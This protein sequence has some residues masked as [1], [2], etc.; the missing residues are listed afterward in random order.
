MR[1]PCTTHHDSKANYRD[2][3][4]TFKSPQPCPSGACLSWI[5]RNVVSLWANQGISRRQDGNCWSCS[6]RSPAMG[7][8][9]RFPIVHRTS[10]PSISPL[11]SARSAFG[12][13]EKSKA[14]ERKNETVLTCSNTI[15]ATDPA[16]LAT[17]CSEK[18][19]LDSKQS[20]RATLPTSLGSRISLVLQTSSVNKERPRF[21]LCKSEHLDLLVWSIRLDVAPRVQ[22]ARLPRFMANLRAS[23]VAVSSGRSREPSVEKSRVS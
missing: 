10:K 11:A 1:W 15:E 7:S 4:G 5:R 23:R 17:L 3:R 9:A 14:P 13:G 21:A 6:C 12:S 18:P 2:S 20:M 22:T 8:A 16:R 19:G